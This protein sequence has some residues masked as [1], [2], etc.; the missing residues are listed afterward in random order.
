M[1]NLLTVAL[2]NKFSF[3]LL[4]GKFSVTICKN[5]KNSQ[6]ILFWKNCSNLDKKKNQPGFESLKNIL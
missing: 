1:P 6:C 2:F 5:Y 3:N 4:N